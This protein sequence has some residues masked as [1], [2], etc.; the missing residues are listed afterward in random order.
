MKNKHKELNVDFIGG[1]GPLT[2]EEQQSISEFIHANKKSTHFK[3]HERKNHSLVSTNCLRNTAR[4][5]NM[6][7]CYGGGQKEIQALHYSALAIGLTVY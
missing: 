6:G 7:C 1:Q 3:H 5:A 4:T 2:K